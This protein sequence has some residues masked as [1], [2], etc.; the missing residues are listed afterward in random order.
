MITKQLLKVFNS[1]SSKSEPFLEF[2]ASKAASIEVKKGSMRT[3]LGMDIAVSRIPVS[4]AEAT[5]FMKKK[6]ITKK[7][8]LVNVDSSHVIGMRRS[9]AKNYMEVNVYKGQGESPD[10]LSKDNP[11]YLLAD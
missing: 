9:L 7:K 10:I 1:F 3:A 11:N 5:E 2:L 8:V 6:G 4:R